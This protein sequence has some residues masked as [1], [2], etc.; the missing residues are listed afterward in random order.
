MGS[1]KLQRTLA[2]ALKE[3]EAVC[4]INWVSEYDV[5]YDNSGLSEPSSK[6]F[7]EDLLSMVR[8][9]IERKRTF[10]STSS[11]S[12]SSAASSA[13]TQ[14]PATRQRLQPSLSITQDME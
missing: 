14:A 6:K 3:Y 5:R 7:L 10:S 13:K 12:G 4:V 11:S 8:R 2:E 9:G 1:I